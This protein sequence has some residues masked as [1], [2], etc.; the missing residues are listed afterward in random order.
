MSEEAIRVALGM[1]RGVVGR[2]LYGDRRTEL[3]QAVRVQQ[4]FGIPCE[5]WTRAP[6]EP[7][8]VPDNVP[9]APDDSTAP[10]DDSE[11]EIDTDDLAVARSA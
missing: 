9:S 8:T 10:S 2:W 3:D 1:S 7:F 11:P 4:V 5:A 6:T